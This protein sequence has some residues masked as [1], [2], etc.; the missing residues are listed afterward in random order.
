MS[1][2]PRPD[3]APC[4]PWWKGKPYLPGDL[5]T[6][7]ERDAPWEDDRILDAQDQA[8]ADRRFRRSMRRLEST[9]FT[10]E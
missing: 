2:Q 3:R 4:Q 5:I 10:F 9:R 7:V 8:E 1:D 6:R